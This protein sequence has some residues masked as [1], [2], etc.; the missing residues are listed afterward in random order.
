MM[1]LNL[2]SSESDGASDDDRTIINSEEY[3]Y[4]NEIYDENMAVDND[5]PGLIPVSDSSEG[6]EEESS[7][8][9]EWVDDEIVHTSWGTSYIITKG[10][11]DQWHDIDL[12]EHLMKMMRLNVSTFG[13]GGAYWF[14]ETP[15]SPRF[16]WKSYKDNVII[17][18]YLTNMEHRFAYT[19]ISEAHL[20][21]IIHYLEYFTYLRRD[22]L[23]IL[24]PELP[25]G[26]IHGPV[27]DSPEFIS[28]I[29]IELQNQWNVKDL[30]VVPTQEYSPVRDTEK[31]LSQVETPT[32]STSISDSVYEQP[33]A[34]SSAVTLDHPMHIFARDRMPDDPPI[35]GWQQVIA[36]QNFAPALSDNGLVV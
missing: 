15:N 29:P 19:M 28:S 7:S 12:M 22:E 26:G 32:S 33:V 25:F 16:G 30:H 13:M 34:S 18:D 35:L 31:S 3:F 23:E 17:F 4:T 10:I 6:E 20:E 21:T 36:D 27:D 11:N 8:S 14:L 1:S 9:S 24:E 5:M 2:W